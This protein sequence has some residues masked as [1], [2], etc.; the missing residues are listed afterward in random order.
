[1]KTYLGVG[2]TAFFL[3]IALFAPFITPL[4]SGYGNFEL[5]QMPP[6]GNFWFGTDIMGLDVFA[7][8]VW[9]ARAAFLVGFIAVS[10]AVVLGA[11]LGLFS[12]YSRGRLSKVIMTILEL[13]LTLPMLPLMIMTAAIAGPGLI[14]AALVIGVLSAP[15]MARV[16]RAAT[17]EVI[18]QPY[19]EAAYCL[20]VPARAIL[21]RHILRYAAPRILLEMVLLIA[22]AVLAESGLSFLGLGDPQL[23]SWGKIMQNAQKNG[24]FFS[25]WWCSFFPG[26]ALFLFVFC[27]HLLGRCLR[28][29]LPGG[30]GDLL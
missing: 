22:A 26:C 4:P 14:K 24:I 27:F 11:P 18:K 9:G 28:G 21:S 16:T 30:G 1:M 6:D 10:A 8:V 2:G 5:V 17:L 19:I 20:G 25:A 7:E 3:L 29:R 15:R 23:W 12:G 13:F